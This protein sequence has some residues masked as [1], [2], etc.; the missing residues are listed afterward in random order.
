MIFH[1]HV[2]SLRYQ[3]SSDGSLGDSVESEPVERSYKVL[4]VSYELRNI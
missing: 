2:E 1:V 4:F 3:R